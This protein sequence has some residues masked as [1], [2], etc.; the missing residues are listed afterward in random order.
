MPTKAVVVEDNQAEKARYPDNETLESLFL[1]TSIA[2]CVYNPIS[3]TGYM[4]VSP[5]PSRNG[6][7]SW[8]EMIHE[9]SRSD[10]ERLA[11]YA[12]GNSVQTVGFDP[13][14]GEVEGSRAEGKKQREYVLELLFRYFGREKVKFQWSPDDYAVRVKLKLLDGKFDIDAKSNEQLVKES[15]GWYFLFHSLY[16]FFNSV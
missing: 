6:L 5:D 14:Q 2:I 16:I 1:G 10:L 11:V 3:K 12:V 8:A 9:E 13:E 7:N 4:A 15:E